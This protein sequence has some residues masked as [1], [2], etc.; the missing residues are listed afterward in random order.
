MCGS[1][2]LANQFFSVNG[3]IYAPNHSLARR[4]IRA[5]YQTQACY[6]CFLFPHSRPKWCSK[7]RGIV[8]HPSRPGIRIKCTTHD[9]I[10]FRISLIHVR[11]THKVLGHGYFYREMIVLISTMLFPRPATKGPDVHS[12]LQPCRHQSPVVRIYVAIMYL[13]TQN[14][15]HFATDIHP[16]SY[17]RTF[18]VLG[19]ERVSLDVGIA[20][21]SMGSAFD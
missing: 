12:V 7:L 14:H 8:E 11:I 15:R 19:S 4:K 6:L 13:D 10:L 2:S 9:F 1:V 21:S 20:F 16:I 3:I 18:S 17:D 5:L